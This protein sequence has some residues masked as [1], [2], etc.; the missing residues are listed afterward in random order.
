VTRGRRPGPGGP[1]RRCPSAAGVAALVAVGALAVPLAG[2]EVR[3]GSYAR[4][5][6]S[7]AELPGGVKQYGDVGDWLLA[8]SHIRAVVLDAGHA[9][10]PAL[11]G[12]GLADVDRVR[13][14]E[15]Y[16]AGHGLD[17]FYLLLPMVN[18][19]V[20]HP[21]PGQVEAFNAPDGASAT[22]RVTGR[23]DRVLALLNLLNLDALKAFGLKSNFVIRTDY[24]LPRDAFYIRMTTTFRAVSETRCT[25]GEDDE[26]DGAADCEDPDC[27]LDPACDWCGL[28]PCEDGRTCDAFFAQCL[29]PCGDGGTCEGGGPC[30]AS[31]RGRVQTSLRG[32]RCGPDHARFSR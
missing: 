4:R 24:E 3:T 2:C 27:S 20:P 8:N 14:F 15:Q 32:A 5:I 1:G 13:P 19:L 7:R 29:L 22:V 21:E 17:Q 11:W 26:G 30:D 23:G 28:H 9:A 6:E 16:R 10:S 25:D 18:L 12:G 31:G